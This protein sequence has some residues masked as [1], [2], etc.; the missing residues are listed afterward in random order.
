MSIKVTLKAPGIESISGQ[1]EFSLREGATLRDLLVQLGVEFGGVVD[2]GF[3][4]VNNEVIRRDQTAETRLK[5][6]DEVL[7]IP[8]MALG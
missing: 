5:D 1:R 2:E 8:P 4:A 7:L 6:G 3:V